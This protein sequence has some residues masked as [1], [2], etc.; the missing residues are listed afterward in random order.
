VRVFDKRAIQLEVVKKPK[1]TEEPRVVAH[2]YADDQNSP[3]AQVFAIPLSRIVV[4]V[5]AEFG[6]PYCS[7]QWNLADLLEIV[8]RR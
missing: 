2:I 7:E 1:A 5:K 3:V 4:V 8:K 6:S